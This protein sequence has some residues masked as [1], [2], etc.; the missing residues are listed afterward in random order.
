MVILRRQVVAYKVFDDQSPELLGK[1]EGNWTRYARQG[2]YNNTF[3][4]TPTLGD[5]LSFTFSGT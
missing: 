4:A 5:T 3:T 1:Y 2:F